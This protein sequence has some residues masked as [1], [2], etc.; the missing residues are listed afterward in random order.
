VACFLFTHT[1]A[2]YAHRASP[3]CLILS[4]LVL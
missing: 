3:S 4:F 1:A 2:L